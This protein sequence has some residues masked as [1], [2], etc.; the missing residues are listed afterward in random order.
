MSRL[1]QSQAESPPLLGPREDLGE[2]REA[3]RSGSGTM[4]GVSVSMGTLLLLTAVGLGWVSWSRSASGAGFR[5][6]RLLP[7]AVY[8]S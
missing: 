1:R 4:I 5:G 7:A 8:C 2:V 6:A 3:G